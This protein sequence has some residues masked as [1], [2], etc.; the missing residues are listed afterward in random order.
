MAQSGGLSSEAMTVIAVELEEGRQRDANRSEVL[1]GDVDEA[2]EEEKAPPEP[3]SVH[4]TPAHPPQILP[5]PSPVTP[6]AARP[7][8]RNSGRLSP[9][10]HLHACLFHRRLPSETL[11]PPPP[12]LLTRAAPHHA[13]KP[14][15]SF[16]R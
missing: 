5:L 1:R 9:L 2:F 6:L 13:C 14:P 8:P 11:R 4:R 15:P 12:S 10:N 7:P 3:T 16:A